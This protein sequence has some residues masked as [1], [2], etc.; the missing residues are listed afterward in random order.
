MIPSPTS[1]HPAD[2]LARWLFGLLA[3]ATL[4]TLIGGV[5]LLAAPVGTGARTP[6]LVGYGVFTLLSI[7]ACGAVLMTAPNR[8]K[9]GLEQ[10]QRFIPRGKLAGLVA[11]GILLVVLVVQAVIAAVAPSVSALAIPLA[12]WCGMLIAVILIANQ[13]AVTFWLNRTRGHWAA[14]GLFL[15]VT[16]LFMLLAFGVRFVLEDSGLM[17]ALRGQSDPRV[18]IWYGG[19][20]NPERTRAYWAE[21]GRLNAAWLPYTYSRIQPHQGDLFTVS[22]AGLRGTV[23]LAAPD[24]GVPA[25]YFF[26]GSTMWG[27]GSRDAYTIPSQVASILD[28]AGQSI[29]ATNYGQVAYI[30]EQDLILFQRQLTLD[31]IP[32]VAVFYGGFNDLASV[33]MH[34]SQI[35]LPHNEVNRARDLAAGIVLRSGRPQLTYPNIGLDQLDFSLVARQD[36]TPEQ[37]VED[38]LANQRI[39]RAMAHEYGVQV[40]F[41]WQP[42]Q[43]FKTTLTPQEQLFRDENN[44]NWPG[45]EDLYREVDMLLRARAAE[46]RL[47]DILFL[48]DLFADET[49]YIFYDRVHVIEDGNTRI[50]QA[51]AEALRPVLSAAAP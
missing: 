9:A 5:L 17:G 7:L 41:V 48:S 51:I 49:G 47:D 37:V 50:A 20:V 21:L 30:L 43:V 32:E 3:L 19:E 45:F 22:D 35:G 2:R 24:S 25:I 12:A 39:I 6:L 4:L 34:G 23:N 16:A 33:Y 27:E 28:A 44:H 13:T 40:R 29:Y 8:L 15:T 18:L 1:D 26:G 31:R 46:S 36:G 14:L 42:A 11:G 38:I 10:A